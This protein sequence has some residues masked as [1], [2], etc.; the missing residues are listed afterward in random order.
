MRA[1]EPSAGAV[2][3]CCLC[4]APPDRGERADSPSGLLQVRLHTGAHLHCLRRPATHHRALALAAGGGVHLQPP[5]SDKPLLSS[6]AYVGLGGC[7]CWV[8]VCLVPPSSRLVT[9]C[10]PDGQ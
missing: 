10:T 1:G 6:A 3:L 8:G 5:V 2:T 4:S 9:E 7:L